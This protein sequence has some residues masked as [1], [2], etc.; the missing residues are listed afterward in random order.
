MHKN[1]VSATAAVRT[2]SGIRSFMSVYCMVKKKKKTGLPANHHHSLFR[3]PFRENAISL[4]EREHFLPLKY[5][6][7]KKAAS[8]R[9]TK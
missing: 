7:D 6:K 8:W 1:T 2:P 9:E 5:Q 4:E 3:T